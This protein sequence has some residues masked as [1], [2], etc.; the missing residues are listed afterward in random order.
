MGVSLEC[1]RGQH[2]VHPHKD[3]CV[4]HSILTPDALTNERPGKW[5][6]HWCWPMRDIQHTDIATTRLNRPR[7]RFSE[8][9]QNRKHTH[10]CIFCFFVL[11]LPTFK[12]YLKVVLIE[13]YTELLLKTK[14][15]SV[16]DHVLKL[17][18]VISTRPLELLQCAP[19]PN[20]SLFP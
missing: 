14:F 16:F 13:K 1:T 17:K 3:C 7:S 9:A 2:W 12:I 11:A 6:C 20:Y 18:E 8:N 5:S 10:P 19:L 4:M 15:Q